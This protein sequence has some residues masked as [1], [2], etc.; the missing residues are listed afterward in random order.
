MAEYSTAAQKAQPDY[1]RGIKA[2]DKLRVAAQLAG[3]KF[4]E[5]CAAQVQH[6]E[7]RAAA[8]TVSEQTLVRQHQHPANIQAVARERAAQQATPTMGASAHGAN[9]DHD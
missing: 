8:R 5:A 9:I 3:A 2:S 4:L 6:E 7:V 1:Q